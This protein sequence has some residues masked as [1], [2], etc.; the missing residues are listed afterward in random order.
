[1]KQLKENDSCGSSLESSEPQRLRHLSLMAAADLGKKSG[2]WTRLSWQG[3]LTG[4]GGGVGGWGWQKA[5][6]VMHSVLSVY[7]P[8]VR[9]CSRCRGNTLSTLKK[10][11]VKLSLD[12]AHIPSEDH[13]LT[14]Q[15]L[16]TEV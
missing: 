9:D 5:S 10:L 12:G 14:L 8:L 7:P 15:S 6:S 13:P 1:M 16:I 4:V 11:H 3:E 2:L